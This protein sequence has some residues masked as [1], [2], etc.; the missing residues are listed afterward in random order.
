MTEQ[1]A[2]TRGIPPAESFPKAQLIESARNVILSEGDDILQYGGALGYA[3]LRSWV[4]EQFGVSSDQVILGQ[5]SLQLLDAFI[6]TNLK[7]G[8]TVFFEQPVYD[9]VLKLF[10][11]AGMQLR[12]FP[13]RQGSMDVGEIKDALKDGEIPKAFYIIPDFQNPSGAEMP[14]DTRIQLIELAQKYG[15]LI[16]EDGAYRHL[17]YK[18]DNLPRLFDLDPAHVLH[19]SSFSKMISPGIRV[20]FMVGSR[21]T[22]L[23]LADYAGDT[24]INASYLNQAIIYDFIRRNLLE[25]HIAFIKKL[26]TERL[27]VILESLE[28]HMNGKG[29]WLRPKGGFFTGLFLKEGGKQPDPVQQKESNLMLMDSR[30]FFIDGNE[31]FIRLPFCAL[32]PEQ[33]SEGIKRLAEIL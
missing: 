5:G 29:D 24:Y 18:G 32:T 7:P 28:T 33:I 11:R 2:F 4:A 16:I 21:E 22:I 27:R 9:R 23:T 1:I 20:G 3:P 17:W 30:G 12:G 31:D 10:R 13:L 14:L 26:Y 25:P 8:E 15:F 19:M 6:K